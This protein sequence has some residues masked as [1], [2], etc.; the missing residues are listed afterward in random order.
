MGKLPSN[1]D[2]AGEN[3][4]DAFREVDE[5]LHRFDKR[6]TVD[7]LS[8]AKRYAEGTL[9]IAWLWSRTRSN[10][11]PEYLCAIYQRVLRSRGTDEDRGKHNLFLRR[12]N[13][14]AEA[15]PDA[16]VGST[17][18]YEQGVFI[19][20]VHL[21]DAPEIVYPSFVRFK[22]FNDADCA[23]G[24]ATN[25]LRAEGFLV[26]TYWEVG[27]IDC[28]LA[29]SVVVDHESNSELVKRRP[30][31]MDRIPNDACPT[32]RDRMSDADA[33]DLISRL[34]VLLHD[35]GVGLTLKEGGDFGFK[36]TKVLFGPVDLYPHA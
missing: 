16:R 31:I 4:D 11:V 36:C 14:H 2:V 13:I 28:A 19:E 24:G 7:N 22:T 12:R 23:G 8:L 20:N 32:G 6:L 15:H 18:R 25:F 5:L 21:M 29:G 3:L 17:D 1:K 33:I 26:G 10:S 30:Q 9:H 35:E 34:R 27:L